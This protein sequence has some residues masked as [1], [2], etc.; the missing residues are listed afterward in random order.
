MHKLAQ[1][2]PAAILLGG[3]ALLARSRA[4]RAMPLRAPIANVLAAYPGYTVQRSEI[5]ADERRVAGMTD[6]VARSYLVD[7][8]LAFTTLVSYYDRQAQGR[9]IHS[10]RN[11]LPGA[12]WEIVR[13][14]TT[15]VQT[16]A[17]TSIVNRDVLKNRGDAALVYYWYQGRGRIVASEYAVK[18]N[19]LRDAALLGH[20]EEALVRIV[21]P[22]RGGNGRLDDSSAALVSADSTAQQVSRRLVEAVTRVL[23]ASDVR[24]S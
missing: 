9:T 13:S 10:P 22:L 14:G 23:P 3:C 4:Q 5:S 2:V 17:G 8:T 21:V 1:F 20:S 15:D 11:C 24:G 7:T 19:L 6:Y 12:G 16:A 18:W